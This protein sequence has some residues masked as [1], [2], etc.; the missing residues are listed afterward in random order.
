MP[1]CCICIQKNGSLQ[2]RIEVKKKGVMEII[3]EYQKDDLTIV[4]QPQ[5]CIHAGICVKTLPA[6]YNPKA[7]RWISAEN[8]SKEELKNQIST[9]PSGA[10]SYREL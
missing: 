8:A 6:V 10:L 3:K 9:C 7:K 2:R 1:V 5:K 4:W